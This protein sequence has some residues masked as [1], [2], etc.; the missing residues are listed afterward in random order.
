MI[1]FRGTFGLRVLHRLQE[2]TIVWL[3]TVSANGTPQP[4][5]VWFYWDGETCLIYTKPDSAK[6]RHI[7]RNPKVALS[8]EGATQAG[9]DV[10][11]LT[12]EAR[13]IPGAPPIPEGY[14]RKYQ[15]VLLALGQT[16]DGLLHEYSVAIRVKPAKYRGF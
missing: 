11:V 9:G 6:L 13:V 5:P 12:G 1:D 2:E 8:F 3:T 16:W 4:N 10:V 14:Q 15:E 7:E